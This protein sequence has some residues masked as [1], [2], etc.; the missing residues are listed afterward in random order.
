MKKLIHIVVIAFAI[1]SCQS[2]T[3]SEIERTVGGKCQG[4]EALYEYG[5]K[6]LLSVDTLPKFESAKTKLKVTGTVYKSDGK[7]PAKNVIIYAYQTNENGIYE[8]KGNEK[9]WGT[10]HGFIRGWVKTDSDGT[11]TFYTF[12]PASYPNTSAP[13]HIHITVK[14]PNTNAYYID[15]VMFEDDKNLSESFKKRLNKHG[16]SGVV[17]PKVENGILVAKRD[18]ILGF[19]IPDYD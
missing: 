13:E 8:K 2:Q 15:D 11:Y 19:N 6:K 3:E 4:C 12:R 1:F 18:I 7:T 17:L 5:N 9:G 14:E 10:R 16:G